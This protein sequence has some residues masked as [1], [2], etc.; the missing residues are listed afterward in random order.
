MRLLFVRPKMHSSIEKEEPLGLLCL[1]SYLQQEMTDVEIDLVDAHALRLD[2]EDVCD[3]A[4]RGSYD[5]LL[6][7]A[8]TVGAP[9]SYELARLVKERPQ[10]KPITIF[11]GP[12]PSGAPEECLLNGADFCVIGEGETV[13]Y[14]LLSTI[15][16]GGDVSN[17]KGIAYLEKD[18]YFKLT[19]PQDLIADLSKLPYPAFQLTRNAKYETTI[20]MHTGKKALPIM[21]S[22]GCKFDCP[23]CCSKLMWR[24]SVRFRSVRNVVDELACHCTI[25]GSNEFHFYDDDF[26][27][28]RAFLRELAE[29]I[30]RRKLDISYTCLS[31]CR[32]FLEIDNADLTLLKKSGLSLIEFGIESLIPSVLKNIHKSYRTE[33]IFS[34]IGKVR[35]ND[36]NAY[37]LLMYMMPGE[38]LNGHLFQAELFVKTFGQLPYVRKEYNVSQDV[39]I[40]NGATYTPFPGTVFWKNIEKQ[41][42][43]LT[44]RWEH[45]NTEKVV[46]VPKS[47]LEEIPERNSNDIDPKIVGKVKTFCKR[48]M[49]V[50][51]SSE[52]DETVEILWKSMDGKKNLFSIAKTIARMKKSI[53]LEVSLAFTTITALT[54]LLND[55]LIVPAR[56][57]KDTLE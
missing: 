33:E 19:P 57:K 46:F 9:F 42:I 40:A 54:F 48:A 27:M 30:I 10:K 56:S 38:T 26:L 18:G 22:R 36:I 7:S 53:P 4:A 8:L 15:T 23:F 41:G 28:R 51:I 25:A 29:E 6:V 49:E 21:V 45:F 2:P 20:H 11:G 32:S 44:R 43:L 5:Y 1:I 37:P 47:L 31:T 17:V 3:V 50:D 16:T 55:D 34:V 24:K 35:R 14:N 12:H 13:L 52:L 39:F